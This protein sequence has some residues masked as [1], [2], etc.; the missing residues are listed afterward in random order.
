MRLAAGAPWGTIG[1]CDRLQPPPGG[2]APV[3]RGP[4]AG[5]ARVPER[6]ERG[7]DMTFEA[8]AS[9]VTDV[10]ARLV[11]VCVENQRPVDDAARVMRWAKTQSALIWDSFEASE[12]VQDVA[13]ALYRLSGKTN[14]REAVTQCDLR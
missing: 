7:Q 13:A 6:A 5:V 9:Y 11:K 10:L 3:R 2:P 8:F 14:A 12:D 1:F 4:A